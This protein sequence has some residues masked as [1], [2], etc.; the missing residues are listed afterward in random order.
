[1]TP[2]PMWVVIHDLAPSDYRDSAPSGS[3]KSLVPPFLSFPSPI[4][5]AHAPEFSSRF[6]HSLPSADRL[7]RPCTMRRVLRTKHSQIDATLLQ[8]AGVGGRLYA[9]FQRRLSGHR[10]DSFP[11]TPAGR[12]S[13]RCPLQLV[14]A[15]RYAH[16]ASVLQRDASEHAEAAISRLVAH[17]VSLGLPVMPDCA[18]FARGDRLRHKRVPDGRLRDEPPGHHLFRVWCARLQRKGKVK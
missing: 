2:H 18:I 3:C 10:S 9:A 13:Q 15:A 5:S 6:R 7:C 14:S 16:P 17:W 8:V 11:S 1:M 4:L 12:N